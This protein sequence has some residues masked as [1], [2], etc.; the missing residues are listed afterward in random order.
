[1]KFNT[2]STA[3]CRLVATFLVTLVLLPT[4]PA[5]LAQRQD[6]SVLYGMWDGQEEWLLVNGDSLR[7]FTF[8][9]YEV[10]QN[11]DTETAT[12]RC[13]QH[14]LR[15]NGTDLLIAAICTKFF[16]NGGVEM[17]PANPE[18]DRWVSRTLF[19]TDQ[20]EN[21]RCEREVRPG[22]W[23]SNNADTGAERWTNH[24]SGTC[25]EVEK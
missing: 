16:L 10:G 4:A 17:M 7:V 9:F 25:T 5:A 23:M 15:R 14:N 19:G 1:M 6:E 20:Y 12:L 13:T 22:T 3:S 2:A 11:A 24:T 21:V 8:D 18:G